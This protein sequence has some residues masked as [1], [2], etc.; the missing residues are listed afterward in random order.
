MKLFSRFGDTL[1]FLR[2]EG[3]YTVG[4]MGYGAFLGSGGFFWLLT[5]LRG[6]SLSTESY[7]YKGFTNY[8]FYEPYITMIPWEFCGRFFGCSWGSFFAPVGFFSGDCWFIFGTTTFALEELSELPYRLRLFFSALLADLLAFYS[9]S[10][11]TQFFIIYG[12]PSLK[13]H[14]LVYCRFFS[15]WVYFIQ[16]FS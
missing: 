13:A 2:G 1:T 11:L 8:C 7:P 5:G 16:R 14:L 4:L 6:M 9:W 12:L 3:G 15:M 10:K